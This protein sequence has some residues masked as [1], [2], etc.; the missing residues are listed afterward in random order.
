[1]D[2]TVILT[3]DRRAIRIGFVDQKGLTFVIKNVLLYVEA[4]FEYLF[5][6]A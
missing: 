3:E 6:G 5:I 2:R 4:H 1:L